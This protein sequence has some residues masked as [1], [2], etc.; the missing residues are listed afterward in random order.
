MAF[1]SSFHNRTAIGLSVKP[2]PRCSRLFARAPKPLC[3]QIALSRD[4]SGYMCRAG[5]N[6]PKSAHN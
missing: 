2:R 3:N 6:W 4:M 5:D 1:A